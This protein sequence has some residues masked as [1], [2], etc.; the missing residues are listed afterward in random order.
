MNADQLAATGEHAQAAKR[1]L[2]NAEVQ[3]LRGGLG[4]LSANT[5]KKAAEQFV[6]DGQ[7]YRAVEVYQQAA[8][9]YDA[10]N[11]RHEYFEMQEK[12]LH[13]METVEGILEEKAQLEADR[14][15]AYRD[16][17]EQNRLDQDREDA[18]EAAEDAY[19]EKREQIQK[20]AAC[21]YLTRMTTLI[22]KREALKLELENV[23]HQLA[24]F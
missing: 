7:H 5:L 4:L 10:H 11:K 18:E 16:L 3:Q 17:I 22:A 24:T 15:K 6:A 2:W 1:Y 23:E 8:N 20:Q 19:F 12:A 21:E 9:R 14:A 13:L